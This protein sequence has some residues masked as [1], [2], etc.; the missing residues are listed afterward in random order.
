[1]SSARTGQVDNSCISKRILVLKLP[2]S[3]LSQLEESCLRN[4]PKPYL[5]LSK[6][7]KKE[8]DKLVLVFEQSRVE[9]RQIKFYP[10]KPSMMVFSQTKEDETGKVK[11]E[12]TVE[13]QG[14]V[15]ASPLDQVMWKHR[16]LSQKLKPNRV[17]NLLDQDSLLS[18]QE[19]TLAPGEYWKV[20]TDVEER[21]RKKMDRRVVET[22][23]DDW[24]E[25]CLWK[26]FQLFERKPRWSFRELND[27][28]QIPANR[29]KTIVN[30]VCQMHRSGPMRGQYELKDEYKTKQQR[31]E[32][33]ADAAALLKESQ[34][35]S[36]PGSIDDLLPL[37]KY[38]RY[39]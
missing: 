6:D 11:I 33:A 8:G 30:Q 13:R 12:G 32:S 38:R 9:E 3:A 19:E 2:S 16:K 18:A 36:T 35:A 7:E 37:G 22:G 24:K 15:A 26:I 23:N 10:E 17:T 25:N 29:L 39:Q 5:L 14:F 1:M 27:E 34:A 21:K 31:D 28:I 4:K 20:A